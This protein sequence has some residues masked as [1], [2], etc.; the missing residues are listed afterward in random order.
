MLPVRF[1]SA[2]VCPFAIVT[3]T[4][5]NAPRVLRS[6]FRYAYGAEPYV[7]TG[8]IIIYLSQYKC[9]H[10]HTNVCMYINSTAG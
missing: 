7:C 4:E 8:I 3:G 5:R 1:V 10:T 9:M 6:K 2:V